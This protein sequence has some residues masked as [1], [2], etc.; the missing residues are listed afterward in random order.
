[1]D[2]SSKFGPDVQD[3]IR[4]AGYPYAVLTSAGVAWRISSEPF[5]P[6]IIF[7]DEFKIRASYGLTGSDDFINY[8]TKLYYATAI[9]NYWFTL[10]GRTIPD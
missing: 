1:M 5:M 2:A 8:Y 4:I 10:K 3:G 9:I 7:L 6:D